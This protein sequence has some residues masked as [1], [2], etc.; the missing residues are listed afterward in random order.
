[1]LS[2]PAELRNHIYELVVYHEDNGGI[3]APV[4][5]VEGGRLSGTWGGRDAH[6]TIAFTGGKEEVLSIPIGEGAKLRNCHIVE[7]DDT[8]PPDSDAPAPKRSPGHICTRSCLLQPLLSRTCAQLRSETLPVFYR[9]N[10]FHLEWSALSYWGSIPEA[11]A[12]WWRAIGDTNL[13]SMASLRLV[14]R[15]HD[16]KAV[17][18]DL[19]FSTFDRAGK[20][21][22]AG[23]L[24][25]VPAWKEC[26]GDCVAQIEAGGLFVRGIERLVDQSARGEFGVEKVVV[27]WPRERKEGEVA[28]EG[29][30]GEHHAWVE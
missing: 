26:L 24:H 22:L 23:E 28:F 21:R 8:A 6:L 14:S 30:G 12:Q 11:P 5:E 18:F 19:R 27:D 20:F 16:R 2:L 13:R 15:H 4:A 10:A 25:G 9:V 17:K 1:M 7:T 3:I 29:W